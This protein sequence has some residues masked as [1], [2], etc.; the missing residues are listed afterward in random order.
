MSKHNGNKYF[1]RIATESVVN[2]WIKTHHGIIPTYD[3]ILNAAIH[4]YIT[5]LNKYRKKNKK[6]IICIPKGHKYPNSAAQRLFETDKIVQ[7]ILISND[8]FVMVAKNIHT[9]LLMKNLR[10]LKVLQ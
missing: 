8:P 5:T 2:E 7:A 4:R 1:I 10:Y 3:N 6:S 9:I